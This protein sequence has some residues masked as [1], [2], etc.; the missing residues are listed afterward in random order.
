V[1]QQLRGAVVLCGSARVVLV[2]GVLAGGGWWRGGGAY[3]VVARL[4][5][6]TRVELGREKGG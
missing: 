5:G 1:L 6:K 2:V 4:K 3:T